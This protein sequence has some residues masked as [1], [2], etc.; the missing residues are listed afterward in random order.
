MN[1]LK[2]NHIIFLELLP[3]LEKITLQPQVSNIPAA[4]FSIE[5][6]AM[7]YVFFSFDQQCILEFKCFQK[8]IFNA[9]QVHVW[10]TEKNICRYG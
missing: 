10:I 9:R 5:D 2:N 3:F 6:P 7:Y 4:L 1:L 8:S